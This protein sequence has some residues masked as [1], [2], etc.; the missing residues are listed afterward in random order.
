MKQHKRDLGGRGSMPEGTAKEPAGMQRGPKARSSQDGA[1]QG[2]AHS[3]PDPSGRSASDASDASDAKA[4]AADPSPGRQS[5][6]GS[7]SGEPG[8]G[9][10]DR[11]TAAGEKHGKAEARGGAARDAAGDAAPAGL[12]R[13]RGSRF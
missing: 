6:K 2:T 8:A 12:R 10:M 5:A 11:S 1:V 4:S 7:H 13:E 3:S 9:G